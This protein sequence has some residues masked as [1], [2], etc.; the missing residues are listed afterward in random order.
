MNLLGFACL[1][2][3]V[4]FIIGYINVSES[5]ENRKHTG[6]YIFE[7]TSGESAYDVYGDLVNHLSLRTI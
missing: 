2:L 3:V 5:R 1:L 7:N 4:I 6:T